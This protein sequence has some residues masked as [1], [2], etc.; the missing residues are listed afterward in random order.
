MSEELL[1]A[2]IKKPPIEDMLKKNYYDTLQLSRGC[3]QED[4][5]NAYRRL[6]LK[7]HP[8]KNKSEDLAINN[9]YFLY[10]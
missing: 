1:V 5:S 7:Y 9:F 10:I 2:E 3:T 6:A 8:K 4:I